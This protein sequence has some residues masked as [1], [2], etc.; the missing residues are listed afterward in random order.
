MKGSIFLILCFSITL[1]FSQ[2]KTVSDIT[3]NDIKEYV[4]FLA[5]D[6]LKG[7]MTGSGDDKLAAEYMQ[8]LFV[9]FKLKPLC[10]NGFQFF[11]TTVDAVLGADNSFTFSGF[12]GKANVDFS[13]YSFSKN[14]SLKAQAVF[15]GYGFDISKDSLQWND[16]KDVDVKGKWAVILRGEPDPENMMSPYFE[17]A[18]ERYKV[19]I[20]KNKGAAGVIFITGKSQEKEDKIVHLFF[21]KN[22]S[23]SDLPVFSVNRNIADRIL[24]KANKSLNDVDVAINRDKKP[25][26]FKIPL[27]ISGNS[28]VKFKSVKTQNVVY[29]LEGSDPILKDEYIVLGAH[30][31]HLG[32]GGNG[33]GSRQ[34]DTIAVHNGADDN[35]SGVAA[36]I[37]LAEKFSAM[38]T[39]FKRSILF[40]AFT[41]EEMGML[42]SDFFV[43]NA[44]VSKTKI[45]AMLNFD[46]IGRMKNDKKT[47][48]ISGTGTSAEWESILD[49]YKV[50]RAF[51]IT[52]SPEGPGPSDH[53][54]FYYENIPVLFFT[55][56]AHDDYH[57]P[58]DDVNKINFDG[59]KMI[60]DFVN[61]IIADVANADK[62]LTFKEAGP[63]QQ[64][65][66]TRFKVKL[67]IMPDYTG[68][69][70]GGLSVDGVSKG[71]PADKGGIK[72]GDLIVAVDGMKV[73]NIDDYMVCLSKLKQGK[74]V[75]VEV[76]RDGKKEVFLIM[77]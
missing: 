20:A 77:L 69:T 50:N 64:K 33:S 15:V 45:K 35:A 38:N 73:S 57:T 59:E 2:K 34:P 51:E 56:G 21:D 31:D 65:V 49:K 54:K 19:T 53:A 55:T 18:N 66:G 48:S 27:E 6:A 75:P 74:I 30:Y 76:I 4:S 52:Y 44:P 23:D 5:S 28:N 10:E 58:F 62:N 72:K 17:F 26:S 14:V 71:G 11:N 13:P 63:K 25:M 22:I 70:K 36:V 16:Y 9:D 60:L 32:M 43:K 61:D 12:T 3:V 39:K 24:F 37:E 68:T 40:V 29:L 67:G 42:G 8:K 46:M 7:R 41:G 47:L 1:V